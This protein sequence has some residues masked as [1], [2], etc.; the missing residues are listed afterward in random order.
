MAAFGKHAWSEQA[1][2]IGAVAAGLVAIALFAAFAASGLSGCA[3][4]GQ[5]GGDAGDAGE[6]TATESADADESKD[7]AA[8]EEP[9]S[10]TAHGSAYG[11]VENIAVSSTLD[12]EVTA[13]A[14][15][16]WIKN[17]EGL[18]S[19]SDASSLQSI[20]ADDGLSFTRD[21]TAITWDAN[22]EDVRYWGTTD[23]ELPFGISYTYRLD[24]REVDPAELKDATG[25][26]EIDIAYENRADAT[27]EV[28]GATR[29]VKLP[30]VMA[31]IV[32]FDTEHAKNV[33]VDNGTT[34][35]QEGMCIA[36]GIGMP[37]LAET[38]GLDDD[39]DLPE[40]V[41]ITAQVTGFDMPDVTTVASTQGLSLVDGRTGDADEA[42]DDVF[43]QVD[44]VDAALGALG[45]GT[46]AMSS[47]LDQ[48][49]GGQD[50]L[51]AAFPALTEGIGGMGEAATSLDSAIAGSKEKVDAALGSQST[52]LQALSEMDTEGLT[53]EQSA[54]LASAVADLTAAQ[55]DA[56]VASKGLEAA[57]AGTAQLAGGFSQLE[58]GL[59]QVQQG[60]GQLGEAT[61]K[62]GEASKQLNSAVN[63]MRDGI[64]EKIDELRYEADSK[65][66]L[67]D[68]LSAE[69][70]RQGAFC[71]N[72][73][74]MPASTTF[75][76]TA[77]AEGGR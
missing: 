45:E 22:G 5:D 75:I 59:S 21:G 28:D 14:V 50:E 18:Q 42:L 17:P 77:S 36:V 67:I 39:V 7:A 57:G 72:A 46:S 37:R 43:A 15:D 62:V 33:E 12:G 41:K 52:A 58:D 69:V 30:Y 26:L 29:D 6:V 4:S 9:A 65:L 71:G 31:S 16:E 68:A 19:I 27:V 1:R 48:I 66:D 44:E 24:G 61:A 64:S 20:T 8:E 70:E 51:A 11:K 35:D 32:S 73:E 53:E 34:I 49:N 25:E 63:T 23:Q 38:L 10:Y 55:E 54:A 76:V 40:K 2:G 47:A 56:A 74:D 13:V 60:Y 3:G